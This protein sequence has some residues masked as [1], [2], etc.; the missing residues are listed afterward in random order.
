MEQPSRLQRCM[1]VVSQVR[2]ALRPQVHND[3][4]VRAA[5]Q[6]HTT[7]EARQ[8]AYK[9]MEH[10]LERS[11]GS[12]NNS[13]LKVQIATGLVIGIIAVSLSVFGQRDS[14]V[15]WLLVTGVVMNAT[16]IGLSLLVTTP[17]TSAWRQTVGMPGVYALEASDEDK[18]VSLS[19][20]VHHNRVVL[21]GNRRLSWLA[22]WVLTLPG[23]VLEMLAWAPLATVIALVAI[24]AVAMAYRWFVGGR[25]LGSLHYPH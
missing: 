8:N 3:E 10:M 13:Y 17:R 11:T 23:L 12:I 16:S 21:L 22:T 20:R 9:L 6:K 15:D 18:Y 7:E 1:T 19:R 14:V 25:P 2:K 5:W 24:G 4:A